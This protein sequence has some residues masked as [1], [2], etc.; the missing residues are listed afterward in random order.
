LD[1]QISQISF[2]NGTPID[3]ISHFRK[4]VDHFKDKS[5]VST[6][7]PT[8]DFEHYAWMSK[9]CVIF[10]PIFGNID[11]RLTFFPRF[12]CFADLFDQAVQAGLA[13]VQTQHP[14]FYYQSAADFA[15]MRRDA[16]YRF[17]DQLVSY[18]KNGGQN[19]LDT[20][21]SSLM[22]VHTKLQNFR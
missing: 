10:M 14:G 20:L 22:D 1:F 7:S 5:T 21:R 9:Q 15:I 13:A 16:V 11:Y 12:A 17:L 6:N 8:L 3:A 4:H 2:T 19:Y 18:A